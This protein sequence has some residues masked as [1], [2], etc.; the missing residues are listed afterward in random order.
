MFTSVP[1]YTVVLKSEKS[2]IKQTIIPFFR[3]KVEAEKYILAMDK[4]T[5]F[6]Q[7]GVTVEVIDVSIMI[8]TSKVE[9]LI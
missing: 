8:P 2:D 7:N 6:F 9:M 5:H 1:G 3:S 4:S